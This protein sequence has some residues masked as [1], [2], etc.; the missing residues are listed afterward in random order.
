VEIFRRILGP[1]VL[2]R[3]CYTYGVK[4]VVCMSKYNGKLEKFPMPYQCKVHMG[5]QVHYILGLEKFMCKHQPVGWLDSYIL[6]S[7]Y[8][9][10]GKIMKFRSTPYPQWTEGTGYVID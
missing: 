8:W 6:V 4:V 3:V 7:K 1:C 2:V 10:S 5:G 9:R